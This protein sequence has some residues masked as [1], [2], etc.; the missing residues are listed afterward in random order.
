MK[1][2]RFLRDIAGPVVSLNE[3]SKPGRSTNLANVAYG[4]ILLV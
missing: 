2:I 1:T 4:Y 3:S